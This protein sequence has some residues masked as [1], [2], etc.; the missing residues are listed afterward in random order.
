MDYCMLMQ[1]GD[2]Q[3]HVNTDRNPFMIVNICENHWNKM[4]AI[5]NAGMTLFPSCPIITCITPQWFLHH[6]PWGRFSSLFLTIPFVL[7]PSRWP[8]AKAFTN[9]TTSSPLSAAL[10]LLNTGFKVHSAGCNYAVSAV[11]P[12]VKHSP[13][14]ARTCLLQLGGNCIAVSPLLMSCRRNCFMVWPLVLQTG[15]LAKDLAGPKE[16]WCT[17]AFLRTRLQFMVAG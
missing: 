2:P 8:D 12:R 15:R 10:Y 13:L 4:N 5:R 17:Q 16:S 11:L 1:I 14:S 9:S 7:F 6:Q 3:V